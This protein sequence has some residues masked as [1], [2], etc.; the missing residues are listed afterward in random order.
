MAALTGSAPKN[1]FKDLIQVS[2]SN[3][4]VD[5]TLRQV[6]DGEDTAAAAYL[7]TTQ[8]GFL[9]GTAATPS[10]CFQPDPNTGWWMNSTGQMQIVLAGTEACTFGP[11][12]AVT[13]PKQPAFL[14]LPS[15]TLTRS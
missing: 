2:N 14:A 13:M 9:Q 8:L 5:A 3:S 15:A 10:G 4:G 1:T 12:G 11:D 6:S 7:S